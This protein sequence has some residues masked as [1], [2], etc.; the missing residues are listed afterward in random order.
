[1]KRTAKCS[2][3]CII[4][5]LLIA[6]ISWNYG[7]DL[8][9]LQQQRT[10]YGSYPVNICGQIERRENAHRYHGNVSHGIVRESVTYVLSAK[11]V[12]QQGAGIRGLLSLQCFCHHLGIPVTI[13]EPFLMKSILGH[14]KSWPNQT[15]LLKF[16]DMF[17]IHNFNNKSARSGYSPLAT[18]EDFLSNA[19]E[20]T[21]LVELQPGKR[22]FT[23]VIWEAT[24]T[25][26]ASCYSGP[27]QYALLG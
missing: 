1:M 3:V 27:P 8:G 26:T 16:S 11:F 12:G 4:Y 18:W 22:K 6:N 20:T 14:V 13:V 24:T 7:P 9:L 23:K 10:N 19:Q 2:L 5:F 25:S 21:I 17:N 15:Y